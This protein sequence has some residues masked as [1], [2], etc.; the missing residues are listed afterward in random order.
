MGFFLPPFLHL[1][2]NDEMT[3]KSADIAL[4]VS[5][6]ESE[7]NNCSRHSLLMSGEKSDDNKNGETARFRYSR[8]Y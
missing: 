6:T 3:K 4:I 8:I 5:H 1:A 7:S 2:Q